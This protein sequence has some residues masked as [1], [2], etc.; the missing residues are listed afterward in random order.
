[1]GTDTLRISDG[2]SGMAIAQKFQ[3]AFPQACKGLFPESQPAFSHLPCENLRRE[4]YKRHDLR[5]L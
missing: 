1:M 4:M 5:H 2:S 3:F